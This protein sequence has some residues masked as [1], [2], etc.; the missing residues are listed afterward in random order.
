MEGTVHTTEFICVVYNVIPNISM[1]CI[2]NFSR[3][4]IDAAFFDANIVRATDSDC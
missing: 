1:N 4:W 3:H 2:L